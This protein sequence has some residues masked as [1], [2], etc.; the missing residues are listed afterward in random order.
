MSGVVAAIKEA[1]PERCQVRRCRAGGCTVSMKGA[2]SLRTIVDLDC[3]A[4]TSRGEARCD[5]VAFFER[6]GAD[7]IVA[8]EL[9]SGSFR[10]GAVAQQLQGGANFA[11]SLSAR[12]HFVPV[13]AYGSGVR[14]EWL[15]SLRKRRVV[16]RGR[17]H[18]IVLIRCGQAIWAAL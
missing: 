17:R 5:Y 4:L 2:R 15:R 8:L 16:Y 14:R 13:L 12:G 3:P 11:E 9:K 10:G 1:V 7:W 18:Q 6:S